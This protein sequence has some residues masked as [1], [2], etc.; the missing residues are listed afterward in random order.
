MGQASIFGGNGCSARLSL[1]FGAGAEAK[2]AA[3]GQAGGRRHEP[4]RRRAETSGDGRGYPVRRWSNSK[5]GVGSSAGSG[6]LGRP[7][8]L[9]A[10]RCSPMTTVTE[11]WSTRPTQR[12]TATKVHLPVDPKI[13]K[14]G[15]GS[16]GAV[17]C[18]EKTSNS[19]ASLADSMTQSWLKTRL[20]S[21][22]RPA[23]WVCRSCAL[24]TLGL[25]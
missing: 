9:I 20:V 17:K 21:Q 11:V 18:I 4:A 23:H 25:D 16:S 13:A 6:V 10:G 15:S 7:L 24:L 22:L 3:R 1:Y 8:T 12:T 14:C 2:A 19:W 5:A